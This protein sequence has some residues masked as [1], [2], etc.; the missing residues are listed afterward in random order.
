MIR[1]WPLQSCRLCELPGTRVH[2]GWAR[3][4]QEERRTNAAAECQKWRL[5]SHASR[6]KSP[7]PD[8]WCCRA[9]GWCWVRM[10]PRLR[11]AARRVQ[12]HMSGFRKT[13]SHPA[14]GHRL[15]ASISTCGER[16]LGCWSRD[17]LGALHDGASRVGQRDNGSAA[18]IHLLGALSVHVHD[19]E[20]LQQRC[21]RRHHLADVQRGGGLLRC[22]PSLRPLPP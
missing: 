6:K 20:A 4:R 22:P 2:V 17:G 1:Q 15:P 9:D 13:P 12:E 16:L 19:G 3:R 5:P 21:H 11:P 8:N 18:R 14:T 7:V 10:G